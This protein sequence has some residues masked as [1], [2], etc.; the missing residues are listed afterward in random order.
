MIS[1]GVS[2]YYWNRTVQ[3][4]EKAQFVGDDIPTIESVFDL[5]SGARAKLVDRNGWV[6]GWVERSCRNRG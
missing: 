6:K 3:Q 1:I 5:K 4:E 2:A